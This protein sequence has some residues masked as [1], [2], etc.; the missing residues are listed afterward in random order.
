MSS[1]L[2]KK[3]TETLFVKHLIAGDLASDWIIPVQGRP[4]NG[5]LGGHV[6]Y[7]L[8][9]LKLWDTDVGLLA[10][11]SRDYPDILESELEQPGVDTTGI[12]RSQDAFESRRF[13][14]YCADDQPL[15]QPAMSVYSD[16]SLDFPKGLLGFTTDSMQIDRYSVFPKNSIRDF[17]IPARYF[18]ASTL[19]C[20]QSSYLNQL[21]LSTIFKK[22]TVSTFALDST[23]GY[24]VPAFKKELLVLLKNITVFFT[25][26][27]KLRSLFFGET[28][29]LWEMTSELCGY[30]PEMVVVKRGSQGQIL[31]VTSSGARWQLPAYPARLVDP[32]GCGDCF[33]GGFMAGF[34]KNYDPLESMLFGNISAS[35]C[36]E[37]STPG[38]VCNTLPG[39][40]EIRIERLK[41]WVRK[42]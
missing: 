5:C 26:E 27:K 19:L 28:N 34:R 11:I 31:Q 24:M 8:A 40:A 7:A 16:L 9:G 38:Q 3:K 33:C 20:C 13:F 22:G 36:M 18:E 4:V 30:G 14:A 17:E 1:S 21:N 42:V 29:D 39:L 10:K 12:I 6:A 35:F 25:S 41:D 23:A 32:T 2:K 37:C 15:D